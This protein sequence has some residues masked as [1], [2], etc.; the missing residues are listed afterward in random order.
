MKKNY[1]LD[2]K[3]EVRATS[4]RCYS[5]ASKRKWNLNIIKPSM[6]NNKRKGIKFENKVQKTIA[7]G[8]MW[9]DKGDLKTEDY[10]IECKYTDKK[11]F[12]ITTNILRKLWND[13]LDAQKL[14]I[15]SIGIKDNEKLWILKI[16]LEKEG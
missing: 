2:C 16:K 1:C 14:P 5:C 13:A 11:S 4:K 3:K 6:K 7:S 9:F 10:M 8:N 12:R 15:L